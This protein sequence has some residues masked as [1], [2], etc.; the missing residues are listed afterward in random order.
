MGWREKVAIGLACAGAIG[1]VAPAAVAADGRAYEQVSP[2]DKGGLATDPRVTVES[3]ADGDAVAYSIPGAVAD[4]DVSLLGA[5]YLARRQASSWVSQAIDPPQDN[6]RTQLARPSLFLSTDL[7]ATVQ[8]SGRAVAPGA[9]DGGGNLYRRDNVTGDRTFIGGSPVGLAMAQDLVPATQRALTG[10]TSSLSHFVF[11]TREKLTPDAA[12]GLFTT[13]A[14]ESVDGQVRLVN[15]LPDGSVDPNG[16]IIGSQTVTPRESRPISADGRRVIFQSGGALYERVDGTTTIL[17]SGSQ[18]D[19]TTPQSADL[20]GASADG[21]VVYFQT[22]NALTAEGTGGLYRYDVPTRTL[23]LV[24]PL[25]D[26]VDPVYPAY[27]VYVS[28]D[29]ETVFFVSFSRFTRDANLFDL[30]FYVAR[31]GEVGLVGTLAQAGGETPGGPVFA[32]L[33]PNGRYLAFT[34]TAALTGYD[35]RNPA[36]GSSSLF[37]NEDGSCLE[38]FRFDTETRALN[39]LSC[40]DPT[41]N[42]NAALDLQNRT[43]SEYVGRTALDDG[44]VFFQTAEQLVPQDVNGRQD[45]Y[46]WRDGEA[47]LISTG[48]SPEDSSLADASADGRDVFFMTSERLVRTDKDDEIDLYDARRGGGLAAQNPPDD[49]SSRCSGESCQGPLTRAFEPTVPSS[50]SVE[51]ADG[52]NRSAP[53]RPKI[54]ATAVRIVR[55][56]TIPVRVK[57]PSRGQITITGARVSTIRRGVA[58]GGSYKLSVRLTK[59]ARRALRRRNLT[60][61]LRVVFHGTGGVSNSTSV[62]VKVKAR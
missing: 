43:I 39:C 36:C 16:G 27:G 8:F 62:T 28:R 12:P 46:E 22:L 57:V 13:N 6:A 35:N 38:V 5:Y 4:A 24:T 32:S 23:S 49:T 40:G 18:S 31:R 14:Y 21:S 26:P 2:P 30:N 60:M 19:P 48:K 25:V 20:V 3:S 34:S 42:R 7:L 61:R 17:L 45:V 53:A 52:G 50:V 44:T 55:G 29:G 56:S 58:R 41:T 9:F 11:S 37:Q 33:S 47:R 54:G 51:F 10:A 59:K 1:V 15:R